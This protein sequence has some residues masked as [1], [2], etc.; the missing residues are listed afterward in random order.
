[1]LATATSPHVLG[2]HGVHLQVLC[3][4]ESFPQTIMRILRGSIGLFANRRNFSRAKDFSLIEAMK[5]LG[6]MLV[7]D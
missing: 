7:K 5:F 1:M 4:L 6:V 2:I 3:L